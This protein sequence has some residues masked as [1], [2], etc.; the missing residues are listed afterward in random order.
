M[1]ISFDLLEKFVEVFMDN[2]SVFGDSYEKCLSNLEA[3]LMH[4]KETNLVLNREK[5]HFM[6]DKGIVLGHKVSA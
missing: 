3:V 4:C 2:F 5:C 1:E 6:V